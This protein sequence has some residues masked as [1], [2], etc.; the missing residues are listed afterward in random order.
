M[1]VPEPIWPLSGHCSVVHDGTLYVYSPSGFQSLD[2]KEGA[3]WQRLPMDISLTGAQ[4]VKAVPGGNADAAK[5]YVV[6]GSVNAT[7]ESWNYPGLMHYSFAQKRWDWV[8]PETWV[9]QNRNHHAAVYME[10]VESILVYSGSQTT[11]DNGPSSSTFLISTKEPYTVRSSPSNMAPPAVNPMLKPW[12]QDNAVMFGGGP[13]NKAV[14]LFNAVEGWHD[15]GVTLTE[16]FTNQDAVQCTLVEGSDGRKVLEKFDMS[17]SPNTITRINL[18]NPGGT[19]AAPGTIAGGKARSNKAKRVTIS[20]WPAYNDT[21]APTLSRRG[22]SVAQ[23][24]KGLA[25]ITG[26]NPADPLCIFDEQANSWL[27]ATA[28]FAGQQVLSQSTPTLSSGIATPT[29]PTTTS[30]D[31]NDAPPA[32]PSNKTRMLTVLGATLGAIFGIASILILL[33]FCMKYRKNKKKKEQQSG[34]IEKD[35]LS[36]ADRGTEFMSEAGGSVAHKYTASQTSLAIATG[37]TNHKRGVGDLGSDAST[38]GLVTKKSPLGY[39]EPVELSKFDLKPEKLDEDR[40]VRQNS[41]R[42][43]PRPAA[44]NANAVIGRSRS[45]GWSKYFANNDATNLAQLPSQRSTYASERTSMA[46]PTMYTYSQPTQTVPRLEIPEFEGQRVSN[47]AVGSPTLGNSQEN[48]P[49][50]PMQ[51]ELGR[52]NSSGSV[53]SGVSSLH[54]QDHYYSRSPVASWTPVGD[55]RPPSSNYTNSV[56]GENRNRDGTSSYYATDAT[57]SFY[58]KSNY[59]SFYPGQTPPLG[60]PEGR[61]STMT[62]FP[63]GNGDANRAH[64]DSPF[65]GMPRNF[66]ETEGREST[67]TVFP[68]GMPDGPRKPAAQDMSWLNLGAGS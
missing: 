54:S 52:A 17:G 31:T 19:I 26:G 68:R 45:S 29:G 13:E 63:N 6:G 3:K 38:A 62:V 34:Y 16:P 15:L 8:R 66:G 64:A 12:D 61:D 30:G 36:F 58:P 14:F 55:D 41:S 42:A 56:I 7:A 51:A 65:P 21:L 20:K 27:N 57:S 9:T 1:S 35:R 33:L 47:V 46:S 5:L 59:S 53:R 24:E 23:D 37:R 60:A 43:P 4:C 67:V 28:L 40:L 49:A 22:Y 10:S 50:Q 11:G 48:L 25:V 32:A 39:T 2:L 18:L 44:A